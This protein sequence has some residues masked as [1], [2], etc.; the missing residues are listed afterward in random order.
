MIKALNSLVDN[1]N[2][3]PRGNTPT[4]ITEINQ[5]QKLAQIIR[6]TR[7][8]WSS[9]VVNYHE[10][11]LIQQLSPNKIIINNDMH[12]KEVLESA[13]N[14]ATAL[15]INNIDRIIPQFRY[16]KTLFSHFYQSKT[17]INLYHSQNSNECLGRHK[18]EYPVFIIQL[19]GEKKW[20]FDNEDFIIKKGDI[21]CIPK[22][23]YHEVKTSSKASTHITIGIQPEHIADHIK[24][25]LLASDEDLYIRRNNERVSTED[26]GKKLHKAIEVLSREISK[27]VLFPK[28][29]LDLLP[30]KFKN[31]PFKSENLFCLYL[32]NIQKIKKEGSN[33]RIKTFGS[34]YSLNIKPGV[35][36]IIFEGYPFSIEDLLSSSPE[37]K[38]ESLLSIIGQLKK[39]RILY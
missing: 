12:L 4:I 20:M 24:S 36:N 17:T 30:H 3:I 1:S 5:N 18:D 38:V 11:D 22:G 31:N 13:T 26:Q 25:I 28:P 34:Q 33:I 23:L 39:K 19:Y 2:E 29:K 14:N 32:E 10:I 8:C 27:E 21:L 6:S 7:K 37:T 35:S 9:E 16:I 15:R